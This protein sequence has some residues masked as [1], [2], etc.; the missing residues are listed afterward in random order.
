[1]TL[2]EMAERAAFDL[3][4]ENDEREPR[5]EEIAD[6]IERV[7]KAFARRALMAHDDVHDMVDE[8]I[9]AAERGE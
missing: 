1:M 8:A 3:I 7:A 6:A 5:P 2:R 9:A 4:A